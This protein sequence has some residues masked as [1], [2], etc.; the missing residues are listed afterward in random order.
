MSHI[1]LTE[2]QEQILSQAQGPVEVRDSHG[3]L[4]AAC[5]PLTPQDLEMIEKA[6]ASIAAGGPGVPSSRVQAMLRKLEELNQIEEI[7]L[8]RVEEIVRKVI[9]GD[10][11]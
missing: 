9:S 7:G 2:E 5:T 1:V 3:R 6:K 11:V 10:P 4:L 8:S